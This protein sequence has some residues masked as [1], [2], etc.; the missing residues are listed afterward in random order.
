MNLVIICG[1]PAS[2]KMTVG[3]ELQKITD[4]KLFHN[5]L[6][7][8][9]VNQFF[10]FG[11][12]NFKDLDK[13]IRFDI[14]NEIAKSDLGGLI[15]TIVWAFN[16]KEDEKYIDEIINVF[17]NRETNVCIVELDCELEERLKRNKHE[18]RLKNKPS[19]RDV[20]ASDKRLLYHDKKYRM[21]S[22]EGELETK[23]IFKIDN[24]SLSA[25]EVAKRVKEH[26]GLK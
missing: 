1:P 8:E 20:V 12:S 7:L 25:E 26:F 14:F 2:G 23:S 10:D 24:T 18:N 5:H 13:K 16:E 9:L 15:F 22:I 4:Y 3:Q 17:H 21:N 11:T 19:K 6:S